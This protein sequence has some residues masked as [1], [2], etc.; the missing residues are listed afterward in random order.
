M[1]ETRIHLGKRLGLCLGILAVV[2]LC[3]TA[4]GQE[5]KEKNGDWEFTFIPYIWVVSMNGQLTVKGQTAEVDASFGDILSNSDSIFAFS[6]FFEARKDVWGM[7][8]DGMYLNLGTDSSSVG[9]LLADTATEVGLF[10]FGGMYRFAQGYWVSPGED[11]S[12]QPGRHWSLDALAGGRFTSIDNTITVT[13]APIQVPSVNGGTSWTDPIV[14][15]RLLADLSNNRKW[16]AWI[17]GDIGG[18]G[19]GSNFT[20]Q[21]L[22]TLS[23]HFPL[24]KTEG[25][26]LLGYR[27]LYQDFETGS[28][29]DK[30][31][32]DMTLHGPTIG[33]GIGW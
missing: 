17:Y 29:R 28:G 5:V 6:G 15:G 31:V 4:Y 24:F 18:F 14:G 1:Q 27:M 19:A 23:Y 25:S 22:A 10:Q 21:A 3:S 16:K 11:A 13:N 7:Y 8:V 32:W 2:L 12:V 9:P 33:F 20:S 26:V 30:F